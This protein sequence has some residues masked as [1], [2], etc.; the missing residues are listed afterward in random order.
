MGSLPEAYFRATKR[1]ISQKGRIGHG[2]F[3][4]P[5]DRRS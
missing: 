5:D 2:D 3:L 1:E 4:D